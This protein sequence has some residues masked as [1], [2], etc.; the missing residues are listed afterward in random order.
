VCGWVRVLEDVK[1]QTE[2]E[3]Y[4]LVVHMCSKVFLS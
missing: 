1:K 3:K 2:K 4:F